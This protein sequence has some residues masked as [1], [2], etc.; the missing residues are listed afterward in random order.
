MSIILAHTDTPAG[1]AAREFAVREAQ[2]R[3]ADLILFPVDDAE[4]EPR[5]PELT[6]LD[7]DRVRVQRP[8]PRSRSAVGDLVDATGDEDV[9]AVV[10]GVRRRSPVGKILL[11]S[12]AQQIIL[13]AECPVITVKPD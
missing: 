12:A 11:G 7:P 8:D 6:G 5:A 4:P 10:V 13:E 2:R 3:D 9:E 1:R